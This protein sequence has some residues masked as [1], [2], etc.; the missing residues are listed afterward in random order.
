M[1]CDIEISEMSMTTL[2]QENVVWLDVSVR[3]AE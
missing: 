1:N 3:A 2:I